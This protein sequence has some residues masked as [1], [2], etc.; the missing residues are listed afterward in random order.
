[1]GVK[2]PSRGTTREK[3]IPVG[4][5]GGG[6]GMLLPVPVFPCTRLSKHRPQILF[7]WPIKAHVETRYIS[8]RNLTP[9]HPLLSQSHR[10]P[11]HCHALLQ[12]A[13]AAASDALHLR[14][15]ALLLRIS[16]PLLCTPT[17]H[18]AVMQACSPSPHA[19]SSIS[20]PNSRSRATCWTKAFKLNRCLKSRTAAGL[21]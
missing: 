11:P 16:T 3:T 8:S 5:S 13:H 12:S 17:S 20:A 2:L 21:L 7:I 1:M 18:A 19:P 4:S 14:I 9:P 10:Q 15:S 6:Y